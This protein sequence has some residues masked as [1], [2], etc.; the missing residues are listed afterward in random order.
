M[1]AVGTSLQ[2]TS[3]MACFRDDE[4]D[5]ART[6]SKVVFQLEIAHNLHYYCIVFALEF[7]F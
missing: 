3:R 4:N 6:K 7:R 5:L 2:H 1:F